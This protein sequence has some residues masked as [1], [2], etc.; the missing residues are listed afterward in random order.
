MHILRILATWSHRQKMDS[1]SAKLRKSAI[2]CLVLKQGWDRCA[3]MWVTPALRNISRGATGH[4][5][6]QPIDMPTDLSTQEDGEVQL[7]QLE[8]HTAVSYKSKILS[9]FLSS[10]KESGLIN[11]LSK[12]RQKPPSPQPGSQPARHKWVPLNWYS[13]AFSA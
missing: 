11:V 13:L 10:R 2:Q 1:N 3:E 5:S 8:T 6:W 12:Y 7:V 4:Q 9:F